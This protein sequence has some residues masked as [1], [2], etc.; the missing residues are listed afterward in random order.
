MNVN[1]PSQGPWP[2]K[3]DSEERLALDPASCDVT[4]GRGDEQ[5]REVY[6]TSRPPHRPGTYGGGVRAPAGEQLHGTRRL[7]APNSRSQT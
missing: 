3:G 2:W 1:Q 6:D 7:R 5:S 4:I